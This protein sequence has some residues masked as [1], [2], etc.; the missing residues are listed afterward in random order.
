MKD[1]RKL[2][3]WK[4]GIELVK[5]VYGLTKKLPQNE[6]YG[7]VSQ[8]NRCAVSVPSNIAEGCSRSSDIELVRFIEIALGSAFELETQMIIMREV[9]QIN[10]DE[11]SINLNQLQK[12]INAYRSKLK[13]SPNTNYQQPITNH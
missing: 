13:A 7:L 10:V 11:F 12:M 8:M 5:Q 9:Y 4:K 6:Q 3:I 2:E 1:F